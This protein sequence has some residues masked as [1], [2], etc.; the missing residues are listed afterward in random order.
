MAAIV[1][2]E[3][4]KSS[5]ARVLETI[6]RPRSAFA[7]TGIAGEGR[8]LLAAGAGVLP[9]WLLRGGAPIR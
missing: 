3:F 7:F 6:A 2:A 1:A 8:I 4:A 5:P 9:W